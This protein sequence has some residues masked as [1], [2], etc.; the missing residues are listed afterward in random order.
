[1]GIIKENPDINQKELVAR[2]GLNRLTTIRNLETLKNHNLIRNKR[3]RNN[4]YYEYVP[5]VEMRFVI[6][7]GLILKFLRNEIN[8]ETFLRLKSKLD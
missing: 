4:V 7:K 3:I 5:D 6:L 8:E 1:L 2:S